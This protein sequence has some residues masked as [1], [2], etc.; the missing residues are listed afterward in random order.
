MKAFLSRRR[1]A[2]AAVLIV[3]LLFFLRPGGS[4]LKSRIV[5]SISAG[6]GRPVDLGAV[7]LRLLPRP[8]FDLEN[9][10]VYDDP[11]FGAEPMLRAN[12]VTADLRLTSLMRGRL[13]IARLDLTD[14]S[15]NLVHGSN[16]RWNVEAL[17]ER[18]AH[19][20]LAPT[21]KAKSEPRPGFPYIAATGARINFKNGPE[22]KPYA[23][24]NADFSLW[25]DSEN[26]W[27][28]RLKAQPFRTDLNLNDTGTLQVTG[29]WQRAAALR[30]TPLEFSMEWNRAQLGQL[31]KF[32]TGSDQGWRGNV[33]L[34]MTLSGTPAKLQVASNAAIQDFRRYDIASGSPLRLAAHCD[35]IYSSIDQTFHETLCS[36]PVGSGL[37]SLKGDVGLL[38]SGNYG[39]VLTAESLPVAA[40]VAL[41]QRAK[42]NL[43][44]DLTASGTVS[45]NFAM[46]RADG[47]GQARL[48]GRGE[49]SELRL[50]SAVNKAEIGP[51]TIPFALISGDSP[52]LAAKR[53]TVKAASV[54]RIPNGA[55]MEFGAPNAGH[56][57]SP[58]VRGWVNRDGYSFSINGETEIG[59]ALRVARMFGVPAVQAATEGSAQID[60]QVSGV[61]GGPGNGTASGFPGA[62]VTGTAALRNVRVGVRG[63]GA[64]VEIASADLRFSPDELRVEKLNAKA[65]ETSWTGSLA[66]PRGCGTPGRCEVHFDLSAKEIHLT[67][68]NDWVNPRPK[69]RPWYH[70]LQ[71]NAQAGI[72]FLASVRAAGRLTAELVVT[73]NFEAAHAS[74]NVSLDGAQVKVSEINAEVLGG[75]YHG[76]WQGDFSAKPAV[77]IGSGSL[78][79]ISLERLADSMKDPWIAGTATASYE[80]KGACPAD[81]WT[82]A[83]GTLQF[84]VTDASLRHVSLAEDAGPLRV[85]RFSGKARLQAGEIEIKDARID[86]ASGKFLVN[87]TASLKRMLDLKLTRISTAAAAPAYAIKGPLSGPQVMALPGVEQARLKP[88]SAKK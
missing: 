6:V 19:T 78:T 53:T 14:P 39:L 62:Q 28:V 21:A 33:L 36:A 43:P 4:R 59:R 86:S 27:G 71:P 84:D 47:G 51:E 35:G 18:T 60:L 58:A 64:P 67:D 81:F 66:M 50:S 80:G 30:D 2:V 32:V 31:T 87:G 15:L 12:E 85:A 69:D 52:S 3:L 26:A 40:A 24:T 29:T 23:L 1:V 25:Q 46:E 7:H 44:D 9:L 70:V 76:E 73:P 72:P 37:I 20:P 34:D 75:T 17:L 22:K 49:V 13:E 10:V 77:C 61:W 56:A 8:G 54:I 41:V 63:A 55:H 68:V 83:D 65:A 38:G 74:A 45:G 79:G 5:L 42:K 57:V 82:V 48:E 88:E 11:A 16:G